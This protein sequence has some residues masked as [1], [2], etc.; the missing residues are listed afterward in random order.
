[1]TFA[2]FNGAHVVLFRQNFGGRPAGQDGMIT[3]GLRDSAVY[4]VSSSAAGSEQLT[5][6]PQL[7]PV[8]AWLRAAASVGRAVGT[9]SV[10]VGPSAGSWTTLSVAGFADPQRLRLR[11][12][13]TVNDG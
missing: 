7:S 2:G 11:A 1:T 10:H 4:Y 6:S 3:V 9:P 8:E 5:N 12:F 13:P